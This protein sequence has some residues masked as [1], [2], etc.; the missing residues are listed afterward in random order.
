MQKFLAR[1]LDSPFTISDV[2]S[3]TGGASKEQYTFCLDWVDPNGDSRNERLVVRIQPGE[4]AAETHRLREYQLM[5]AFHAVL[6]VPRG[7]WIDVDGEDFGQP[8]F[9]CTFSEGVTKPGDSLDHMKMFFGPKYRSIIA[10]Q[11]AKCLAE[12]GNF[13]WSKSDLSSFD[14]PKTGTDEGVIW[15]VNWWERVWETDK[16]E[17]DPLIVLTAHWL[18]ENAPPIDKVSVVHGDYRAGNFLFDKDSGK[19]TAILDWELAFLGDRHADIAYV[20]EPL[21]GELDE[22]G[23]FLVC[24]LCSREAFLEEYAKHSDMPIDPDRLD[25]YEVMMRWRNLIT[26][27]GSGPRCVVGEK[28][29]QDILFSWLIGGVT[30]VLKNSLHEVMKDRF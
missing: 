11:F 8:A 5:N 29:H 20:T 18:R 2:K 27:I 10:P 7:L 3:L 19:I 26:A 15:H 30:G 24:G 9:I 13:D 22:N 23:N 25:Y 1:Q 17:A 14:V 6:P 12:I 16:V 28:S 4:S 21:Q